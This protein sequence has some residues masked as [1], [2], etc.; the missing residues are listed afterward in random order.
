M[1]KMLD[2]TKARENTHHGQKGGKGA[3]NF[4][5][6]NFSEIYTKYHN[7]FVSTTFLIGR[8]GFEIFEPEAATFNC[9]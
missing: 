6:E 9:L 8:F 2:D 7:F 3:W 4:G 5:F 1:K